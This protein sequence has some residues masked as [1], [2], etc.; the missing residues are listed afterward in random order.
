MDSYYVALSTAIAA[1]TA[2]LGAY[3]G[4]VSLCLRTP[5]QKNEFRVHSLSAQIGI[6]LILGVLAYLLK[7]AAGRDA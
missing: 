1:A 4:S 7:R 6:L 2:A 5:E 3:I